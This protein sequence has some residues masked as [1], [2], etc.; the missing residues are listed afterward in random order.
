M[1][2]LQD[3][4]TRELPVNRS[5]PKPILGRPLTVNERKERSRLL[6]SVRIRE[7]FDQA[8][9]AVR[10]ARHEIQ[11]LTPE[12]ELAL[13]ALDDHLAALRLLCDKTPE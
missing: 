9:A 13:G 7:H 3:R 10:M 8:E 6:R 11:R 1:K 12:I 2:Q 4:V 5:G